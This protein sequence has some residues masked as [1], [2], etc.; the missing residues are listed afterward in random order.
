MGQR[1]NTSDS[2][3]NLSEVYAVNAFV[4]AALLSHGCCYEYDAAPSE[5][6]LLHNLAVPSSMGDR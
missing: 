2:E 3:Y 1:V 5:P 4:S 6:D